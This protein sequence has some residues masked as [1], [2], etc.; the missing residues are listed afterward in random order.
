MGATEVIYANT[1]SSACAQEAEMGTAVAF[2]KVPGL[3]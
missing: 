1:P 3:F 2:I